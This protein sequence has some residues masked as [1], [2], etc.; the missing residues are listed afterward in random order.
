MIEGLGFFISGLFFG[1]TAGIS[2]GPLLALV[3][4]ET[5]KYGKNEGIKIAIAPLIT[6]LPIILFVL[7]VVSHLAKYS[8][9]IG[10]LALFGAGYLLYLG[11]E[12][13]RVKDIEL[14]VEEV[15]KDALKKGIITNMLNP[16]PYL[17][18]LSIGGSMIIKSLTINVSAAVL[19]V[20]GFYGLLVGS[21][22]CIALIVEKSRLF[23]TSRYYRYV[24]RF[25]GIVLI[26]FALIFVK[27]GL[28]LTGLM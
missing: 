19:F 20:V 14:E 24:I 28:Q 23:I 10:V 3:F 17:F 26:V 16:N 4:S 12:N 21:K 7:V 6:D 13:L 11:Y 27:E 8:F 9:L 18:W 1:L 2:P 22:I 25:L 15:K 5:L